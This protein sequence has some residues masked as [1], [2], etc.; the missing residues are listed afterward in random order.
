MTQH[1]MEYHSSQQ[2]ELSFNNIKD[3]NFIQFQME[4]DVDKTTDITISSMNSTA[5]MDSLTMTFP[6]VSNDRKKIEY[7]DR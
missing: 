3:D 1:R 7:V 5:L 4:S 2:H 6:T